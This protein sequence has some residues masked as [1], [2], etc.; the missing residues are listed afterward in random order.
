M[1]DKLINYYNHY[2]DN[3]YYY[4]T[5]LLSHYDYYYNNYNHY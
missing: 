3:D 5:H 1:Y 2:Y 4:D